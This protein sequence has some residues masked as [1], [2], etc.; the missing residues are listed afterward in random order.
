MQ[1]LIDPEMT[2]YCKI[3]FAGLGALLFASCTAGCGMST[4]DGLVIGST[5]FLAEHNAGRLGRTSSSLY[6]SGMGAASA[7]RAE[8]FHAPHS[9]SER[10]AVE[11]II[12]RGGR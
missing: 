4:A 11:R 8:D 7:V 5:G 1:P 10:R 12:E 9:D 2:H 3:L 6:A